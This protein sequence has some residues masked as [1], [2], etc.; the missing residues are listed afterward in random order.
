MIESTKGIVLSNMRYQESSLIAH[1][2]TEKFGRRDY[3]IKGA[4]SK[5]NN[6]ASFYLPLNILDLQ[7]YEKGTPSLMM[8]KEVRIG[9]MLMSLRT[10]PQKSMILTFLSELLEKTLRSDEVGNQELYQFLEDSLIE[11]DNINQNWNSF[12]LQ[13]MLRLSHHL[14]IGIA[15]AQ[16]LLNETQSMAYI[17]EKLEECIEVLLQ[18]PY[19]HDY[20]FPLAIRREIMDHLVKFYTMQLPNFGELTSLRILREMGESLR[21][22]K[23]RNS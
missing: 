12:T 8:V 23:S 10:N 5:K 11:L 21:R 15:S 17:D 7:V 19:T 9:I 14:G 4:Y 2:Y 18:Q 20:K 16:M 6:K 13:F 1:V 3:I 22:S